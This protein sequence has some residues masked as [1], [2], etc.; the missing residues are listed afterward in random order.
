MEKDQWVLSKQ[1][2]KLKENEQGFTNLWES[3]QQYN[4]HITRILESIE[5]ENEVEVF[6]EILTRKI[7]SMIYNLKSIQ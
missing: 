1:R 5:R 7:S 3:L 4:I 6:E 2:K